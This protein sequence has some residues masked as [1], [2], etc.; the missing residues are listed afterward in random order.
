MQKVR[1]C[2]LLPTGDR[3]VVRQDDA[4]REVGSL[5]L[6]NPEA[7]Q[8]GVV[9]AVS[10]EVEGVRP[11]DRVLFKKHVATIVTVADVPWLLL[12]E[13]DLLARVE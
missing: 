10:P 6:V 7:P 1:K 2:P 3:V 4:T 9:V 5:L 13:S 12:R 8:R 11:R